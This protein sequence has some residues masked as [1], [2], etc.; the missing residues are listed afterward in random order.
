MV[1]PKFKD[2]RNGA[3]MTM[4]SYQTNDTSRGYLYAFIAAIC[5]GAI[6]TLVK[7][8]LSDHGPVPVAGLGFLVSGIMLLPFRPK[9]LPKS[10]GAKFVVFFALVGAGL[11]PFLWAT[12]LTGTTAVNA[13]LLANAEV[14]FTS[15][16][17]YSAFGERLT[18]KQLRYGLLIV[19]GILIVSTN[20]DLGGV[21][22]LQGL[23]G[24]VLILASTV[25]WSVENNLAVN[26][27]R[28]F[29]VLAV[30]KFR[31]L[32]GGAILASVA[33]LSGASLA[34]SPF[35]FGVLLILG[36]ALAS[37]SYFA[38]AALG[39]LGAIR[40]ILVFS[41]STIFGAIFALVFLREQITLVQ[42][43]GGV[44]MLLGIYLFQRSERTKDTSNS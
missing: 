5:G 22:F 11:A 24:N 39:K 8:L 32:I 23:V 29:G 18:N 6:P 20:L 35:D 3:F 16:I 44:L 21:Q 28:R 4:K 9:V 40:M 14:F 27:T 10:G 36:A 41:T 37:A 13:S 42:I 19:A 26:A 38:L 17:A 34:F 12:G 43:T 31:N 33:L 25:G 1:W 15:L 30:T 7:F 2:S